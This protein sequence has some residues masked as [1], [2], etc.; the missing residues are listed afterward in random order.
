[1]FMHTKDL[2]CKLR[3]SNDA[4]TTYASI[5]KYKRKLRRKHEKY[6]KMLDKS[7]FREKKTKIRIVYSSKITIAIIGF[8]IFWI[9]K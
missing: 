2:S 6:W 5:G 4:V 1:M 3:F 8:L 7:L 9:W